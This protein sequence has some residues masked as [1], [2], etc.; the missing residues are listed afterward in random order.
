MPAGLE[1]Y[2]LLRGISVVA[3]HGMA[4]G[5]AAA[6]CAAL[7]AWRPWAGLAVYPVV[8]FVVGSRM[9]ALGNVLHETAHGTYFRHRTANHTLGR[10]LAVFDF[11][12]FDVYQREHR[13][14]HVHL[15]VPGRD[16][17]VDARRALGFG[18]STPRPFLRHVA[19]SLT[20]RH[21][22]RYLRPVVYVR[23]ES[24]GW[25]AAR[26]AWCLAL[27]IGA[28]Q[29]PIQMAAFLVLPW[30]TTYQIFRYWSDALDHAGLVDAPDEFNRTRNH[31]VG[32]RPLDLL[33]FP[34]NDGYHL[35]HHLFPSVPARHLPRVHREV[36][37]ALPEYAA[38][39]HALQWGDAAFAE[40]AR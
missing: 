11:Q 20:L 34:R 32:C 26:A 21:L 22:P 35:A 18:A 6:G 4:A 2:S 14:H 33:L 40:F 28:W 3:A 10:L 1:A 39:D 17:D 29:A 15:G 8:A 7:F 36:L 27:V 16:V 38:R 13:A 23:G 31:V 24:P 9:R 12:S 30:L 19:T 37:M 25:K 5:G